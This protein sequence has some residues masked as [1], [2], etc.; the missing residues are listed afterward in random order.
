MRYFCYIVFIFFSLSAHSQ[1]YTQ[2]FGVRGGSF[3]GLS[4]RMFSD[5]ENAVEAILS[6]RNE[7]LKFTALREV[8][9]PAYIEFSDNLYFGYGFG[10]HMGYIYIDKYSFFLNEYHLE[11]KKVAPI[12]GLDALLEIEYRIREFPF[13]IGLSYKPYMQFSTI[14]FFNLNLFDSGLSFKYRF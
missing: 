5:D 9:R 2:D 4:Y 10:G 3:S 7:G 13:I 6:F 12:L 14:Q 11:R 8:Y 1:N